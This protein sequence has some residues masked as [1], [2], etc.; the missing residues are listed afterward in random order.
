MS[1]G[2]ALVTF[3]ALEWLLPKCHLISSHAPS[4]NM[5]L[6]KLCHTLCNKMAS[7]LSGSSHGFSSYLKLRNS[8]HNLCTWM[9]SP[10]CGSSHISLSCLL[11]RISS[12]TWIIGISFLLCGSSLIFKWSDF[13][14]LFLVTLAFER[15]LFCV[16]TY[17]HAPSRNLILKKL[18]LTL[19]N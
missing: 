6:K 17:S 18:C 13:E 8:C 10:P 3:L 7:L 5:I 15:L 9:T 19:C 11:V 4:R 16:G 14:K 12:Y 1:R 2:G